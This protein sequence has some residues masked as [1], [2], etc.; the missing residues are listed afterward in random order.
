MHGSKAEDCSPRE[1]AFVRLYYAGTRRTRGNGTRSYLLAY[2]GSDQYSPGSSEYQAAA[3]NAHR[4][5]NRERVRARIREIRDR[6][7]ADA[8]VRARSWWE[9]YDAARRTLRWAA[10]G[11][12][13]QRFNGDD[14]D[15]RKRSAVRAAQEVVARCEGTPEQVHRHRLEGSAVVFLVAGQEGGGGARLPG[16]AQEERGALAPA[17]VGGRVVE[18]SA[19]PEPPEL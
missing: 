14:G 16:G 3:S 4:L 18:S 1:E 13:P 19:R 9:D 6:A 5:L 11:R 2:Y 10:T 7:A 12:W 17:H 15:E 8:Q